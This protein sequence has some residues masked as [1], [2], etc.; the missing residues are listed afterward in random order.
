MIYL[1]KKIDKIA[2]S[3]NDDKRTQLIDLKEAYAFETGE[4]IICKNEEIKSR[5]LIK[6][7]KIDVTEETIK[8][9]NLNL[10]KI[11]DH[12]YRI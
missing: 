12:P 5:N 10:S 7:C 3:A 9:R 8:L 1:L 2:L 6:Q 11:P 4:N